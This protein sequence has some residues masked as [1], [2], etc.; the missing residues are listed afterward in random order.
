MNDESH[1]VVDKDA[2]SDASPAAADPAGAP[3]AGNGHPVPASAAESVS[4]GTAPEPQPEEAVVEEP[5]GEDDAEV[6]PVSSAPL[7]RPSAAATEAELAAAAKKASEAAG[8]IAFDFYILKVQSNREKSIA[9]A[10][11]R[12][13][14]VEGLDRYFDKDEN[15]DPWVKVPTEKVTEFKAGK[16]KIVERKLYPG[17]IV[18]KMHITDET[19]FAVRD[20]SGIGDFTGAGGKPSPM[21]PHEVARIT[22]SEEEESTEAPKLDIKFKVADRVKVKDGTF[23]GFEGEVSVIDAQSGKITVMINIF[24]RSTPVE[25]EYWQV[26]GV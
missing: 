1:N 4:Q 2:P 13:V 20:T 16:K 26:E 5:A 24:G 9:A 12:K 19:W 22:Q 15:G 21:Q 25:L 8:E 14:R 10:L 7:S 17:Y 11:Q 18:V 23:E 6:I 3:P